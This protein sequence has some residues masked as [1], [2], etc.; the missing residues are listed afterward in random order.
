MKIFVLLSLIFHLAILTALGLFIS[1]YSRP[2][3]VNTAPIEKEEPS[4]F[5]KDNKFIVPIPENKGKEAL[6]KV[7]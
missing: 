1:Q 4:K 6:Y 3:P 7:T 2:A 5:E